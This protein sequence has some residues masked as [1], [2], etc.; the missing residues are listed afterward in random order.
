MAVEDFSS[1]EKAKEKT[2]EQDRVYFF[3][4][5]MQELIVCKR[6]PIA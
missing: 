5:K 4:S 1:A 6:L 3:Y 2:K